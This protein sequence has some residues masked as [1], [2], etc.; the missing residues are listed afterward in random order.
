MNYYGCIYKI[1]N[2]ID[3]KVYIGQTCKENPWDRIKVHFRKT[4]RDISYINRAINHH[5]KNNF[6]WE[7]LCSTW[8]KENLNDLERLFINKYNSMV[9]NGYNLTTG[10][11]S[12]FRPTQD[13]IEQT[14]KRFRQYY[15]E[16]DHPFKGKKF[17]EAH[18]KALSKVRKGFDSEA[19]QIAR[20]K[21]HE[22]SMLKIKAI[23]IKTQEEHIFNS[24]AEC[25]RELNLNEACV[26]RTSKGSQNRSQHKGWKFERFKD[27][28]KSPDTKRKKHYSKVGNSYSVVYKQKYVC[29]VKT[30]K[31]A[32]DLVNKLESGLSPQQAIKELNL[33]IKVW[34][35]RK[36]LKKN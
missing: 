19:R 34:Q 18:V 27:G 28:L 5:S 17:S 21:M 8:N 22:A 24:I 25:A 23:N 26:S 4:S 1:T 3:G 15:K 16:H 33:D 11:D 6:K 35:K 2:L 7:I 14:S 12:G 30:E 31:E 13:Q 36:A 20:K 9:P 32:E 29:C 10:G